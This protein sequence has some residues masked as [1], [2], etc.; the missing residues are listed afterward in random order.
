MKF[1]FQNKIYNLPTSLSQISLR[2]KIDYENKYGK[3]LDGIYKKIVGEDAL[4]KSAAQGVSAEQILKDENKLTPFQELELTEHQIDV[5]YKNFAFFSQ[6]PLDD[7]RNI[8][9]DQVLNIY[10]SCYAQLYNE[11]YIPEDKY[12]WN[13]EYWY[14]DTQELSHKSK[15]TFNEFVTAKQI[16]KSFYDLGEGK[17]DSLPYLCAIFLRKEGEKF[18]EDMIDERAKLM[19]DLPLNIAL[20]V[21]FFL[22]ISMSIY[23]RHLQYSL[24]MS[25]EKAPV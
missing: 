24:Q 17:W 11:E 16:V 9:I 14:I 23:M 19:Y 18:E 2:Q 4:K 6:I 12:L 7:A 10:Y 22:S 13:N 8:E 15:T 5:A 25:E 20:G 3:E 21:A 1:K